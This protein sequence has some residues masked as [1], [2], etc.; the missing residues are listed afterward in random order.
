M[1]VERK[2]LLAEVVKKGPYALKT[3]EICFTADES[4]G[5]GGKV[6]SVKYPKW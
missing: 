4:A 5:K 6:L 2:V 1:Q 3:H